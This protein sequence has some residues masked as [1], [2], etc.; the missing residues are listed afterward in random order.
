VADA[1][2]GLVALFGKHRA[3]VQKAVRR[4]PQVLAE[5][6]VVQSGGAA[7]AKR[8]QVAGGEASTRATPAKR[9]QRRVA[10]AGEHDR[11]RLL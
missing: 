1:V 4:A 11:L 3:W 5:A 2:S 7:L 8:R 9:I 6:G 10:G